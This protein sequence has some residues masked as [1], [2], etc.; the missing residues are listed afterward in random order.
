MTYAILLWLA[1]NIFQETAAQAPSVVSYNPAQNAAGIPPSSNVILTFNEAVTK[2]SGNILLIPSSG[3]PVTISV[4]SNRVNIFASTL[5]AIDPP[6]NLMESTQYTVTVAAGAFK[7]SSD[8]DFAGISGTTYQFTTVDQTPPLLTDMDPGRNASEI[9][10]TTN[11]KL[12][13]SEAVVAGTGSIVFSPSGNNFT[14]VLDDLAIPISDSQVSFGGAVVTV[15]P[16]GS[17]LDSVQYNV[18]IASGVIIDGGGN[19]FAGLSGSDYYFSMVDLS[20]PAVSRYNPGHGAAS[21]PIHS[22]VT[23]SFME[24]IVPGTGTILFTPSGLNPAKAFSVVDAQVSFADSSVTINPALNFLASVQYT[25]TMASGVLLDKSSNPFGGLTGSQYQ[26]S[27]GEPLL[28]V[29]AFSPTQGSKAIGLT[30]TITIHFNEDIQSGT[31]AIVFTPSSGITTNF[32]VSDTT[33]VTLSTNILTVTPTGANTLLDSVEYT[34]TIPSGVLKDASGNTR[35]LLSGSTYQFS[36]VDTNQPTIL[37]YSP[38]D[39]TTNVLPSTNIVLTFSELVVPATGSITLVPSIGSS[40]FIPVGDSQVSFADPPSTTVTIDPTSN[41]LDAPVQYAVRMPAGVI[42]DLSGNVFSGLSASQ[43]TFNMADVTPPSVIAYSPVQGAVNVAVS[44]NIV[45]TF[46]EHIVAGSGNILLSPNLGSSTTIPISDGQVTVSGNTLTLDSSSDLPDSIT[47]TITISSGVVK[48]SSNNG[49]VGITGSTYQF[50]TVDSTSPVV[51]FYSPPHASTGV[52]AATNIVLEFNEEVVAGSGNL[53]LEMVSGSAVT[54]SASDERVSFVK[55]NVIINPSS[56]LAK[57]KQYTLTV[58]FGAIKDLSGNAFGGLS[59]TTYQFSTG[60][61]DSR[62]CYEGN[63]TGATSVGATLVAKAASGTVAHVVANPARWNHWLPRACATG[64]GWRCRC[65]PS[66]GPV[67]AAVNGPLISSPFDLAGQ[68]GSACDGNVPA[69]P[70][71]RLSAVLFVRRGICSFQEKAAIAQKAGYCG[72][73][74]ANDKS[75]CP[76]RY[77]GVHE[78]PD[79]TAGPYDEELD[80]PAWLVARSDADILEGLQ[81]H[82]TVT[83][84]V[85]DSPRKPPLGNGE[86]DGFGLRD[87][88][89]I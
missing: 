77:Y 80:I 28:S 42:K 36:T 74:V 71:P 33:Q 69:A 61:S 15:D 76:H 66:A 34:V 53:M 1:F 52:S 56:Y 45:L 43:Y 64:E 88:Q 30:S 84:E 32:A 60:V 7:D 21:V 85:Q 26:F 27:T 67:S 8:N 29:T 20:P 73:L 5:V 59:G 81:L 57:M 2:G 44:S 47:F 50:T 79:M 68:L 18:F 25:I 37:S 40:M 58:D 89:F 22:D 19:H 82:G 11:V 83:I 86:T 62:G 24:S 72:L 23:I 16:T 13:F 4:S 31:G 55:K 49:V 38:T 75:G 6:S 35:A 3:S 87:H 78:V 12:S 54:Y 65:P 46:S 9:L 51:V 63:I 39:T 14:H 41:L 48:D 10:V 70:R 17:L